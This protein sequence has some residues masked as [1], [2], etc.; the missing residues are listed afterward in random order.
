MKRMLSLLLAAAL[1]T[2][3]AARGEAPSV[4]SS[5]VQSAM[6]QGEAIG[7]SSE[8]GQESE[9]G[10]PAS[11]EGQQTAQALLEQFVVPYEA[12]A[13]GRPI[14]SPLDLPADVTAAFCMTVAQAQEEPGT[15]WRTD[16][17]QVIQVPSH[18]VDAYAL[19]ILGIPAPTEIEQSELAYYDRDFNIEDPGLP[20]GMREETQALYGSSALSEDPTPAYQLTLAQAE[21][22]DS[23]LRLRVA[24]S[25]DGMALPEVIYTFQRIPQVDLPILADKFPEG[26]YQLVSVEAE[27]GP[28]FT[29]M[30][31]PEQLVQLAKLV[32]CGDKSYLGSTFTLTGDIDMAGVEMIPIGVSDRFSYNGDNPFSATFDGQGH[33]ISNLSMDNPLLDSADPDSR[34]LPTGLFGQTSQ[35]AVIQNL[36]LEG[37]SIQGSSDVG[38]LVGSLSGGVY[39]CT[40]SGQVSGSSSVGGMVGYTDT[41]EMVDCHVEDIQVTGT[42][43][44]G[45][46]AGAAR[47][48]WYEGCSASGSV[49]V[50]ADTS[51]RGLTTRI[52]GGFAGFQQGSVIRYCFADVNVRTQVS[53]SMVGNFIGLSEYATTAHSYACADAGGSWDL[54]DD[55]H[56]GSIQVEALDRADYQ[57]TLQETI[58]EGYTKHNGVFADQYNEKLDLVGAVD[59]T[60]DDLAAL[61]YFPNEQT[62]ANCQD[63]NS[64]ER[65]GDLLVLPIHPGS[66]VNIFLEQADGSREEFYSEDSWGL[67]GKAILLNCNQSGRL[68]VQVAYEGRAAE[69]YADPGDSQEMHTEYLS[70]N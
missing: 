60:E 45:G 23:G 50:V 69:C 65:G 15:L 55:F 70:L 68:V 12:V 17:E 39:H 35:E 61:I 38:G 67:L 63:Y 44:T 40:V 64:P 62:L 14:Q 25:L 11:D 21:E 16:G 56:G 47:Q 26:T 7:S 49:N 13:G 46:L 32:N 52:A 43:Q 27:L 59:F 31:S 22:I 29:Q 20:A 33:T 41:A 5:D 28:E 57:A 37:V 51:G 48:G 4:P 8:A 3:C 30:D 58:S 1:L 53:A 34:H 6:A 10:S 36:R 9:G 2:G 24:R 54:V 19:T 66:A 42:D 18:L